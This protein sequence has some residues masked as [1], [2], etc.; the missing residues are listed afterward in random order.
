MISV[1]DGEAYFITDEDPVD[2]ANRRAVITQTTDLVQG[3][4]QD[5][6]GPN[7]YSIVGTYVQ[8]TTLTAFTLVGRISPTGNSSGK[9]A[10]PIVTK[11]STTTIRIGASVDRN[12]AS[13]Q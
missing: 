4:A 9:A 12:V 11:G 2:A 1:I 10:A 8:R 3:T 13:R 5:V 7:G 6:I